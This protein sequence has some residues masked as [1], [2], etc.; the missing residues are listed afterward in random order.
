MEILRS[1]GGRGG[2][3]EGVVSIAMGTPEFCLINE[4]ETQL[5][6]SFFWG[7]TLSSLDP[8]PKG[9]SN[10]KTSPKK[11]SDK[12]QRSLIVQISIHEM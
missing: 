11:P 3:G 6:S 2:G 9:C 10:F 12:Y 8:G 5:F 1:L 7:G 4:L